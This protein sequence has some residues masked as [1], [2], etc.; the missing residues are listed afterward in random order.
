MTI[1]ALFVLTFTSC[2]LT[3]GFAENTSP[4]Y[5]IDEIPENLKKDADAVIRTEEQ[6]FEVE[7]P[8]KATHRYKIAISILKKDHAWSDFT[9]H[10]NQWSKVTNI[11]AR[12][13]DATGK[14]I[15]KLEKDEINDRAAYDGVS[16]YNDS[17]FKH[18][19]NTYGVV[20]YTFELEYEVKHVG[21]RGYPD[22]DIQPQY[23]TAVQHSEYT[24]STPLSM[25]P[26]FK[27]WNTQ[28]KPEETNSS[29]TTTLKWAANGI[30]PVKS[31]PMSP[32]AARVLPWVAISPAEFEVEGKQGRMTDWMTFGRFLYELN[33]D[34]D[35]ISPDLQ[36]K[37]KEMTASAKTNFEKIDTLY[38]Y[39]QKNMRY[40]SVQL[41]IGGWQTF[42]AS[43]VEQN[44]YGDCKA[45]SN[46]MKAMLKV[47][48]IE[49]VL[50]VVR[51]GDEREL[52][53]S[54]DFCSPAFNHMILHIPSENMWLEC[55]ST[56]A[57]TGY[58]S[59][60]TEGRRVLLITREGGKMVKTPTSALDKNTQ[61]SKTDIVLTESGSA[62][63]KNGAILRGALH[64]SWRQ[65]VTNVSKEE[66]QKTF[67]NVL[68]LPTYT[69]KSLDA[70]PDQKKPE[71]AL[72]YELSMEKYAS[73]AG[74]RLFVPMNLHNP[75]DDTPSPTEK[76]NLPIEIGGDGYAENDEVTFTM[77]EGYDVE[78]I[79]TKEFDYKSE[80]GYY[81]ATIERAG[82]N[83]LVYK[84][85]LEIRPVHIAADRF[86]DLR[87]F[88]KKIQQADTTKVIL[89]KKA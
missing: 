70:K 46:F 84:R 53:P 44:K 79:P 72:N 12:F 75:F 37:V 5:P 32:P 33:K 65:L 57:P 22:W 1:K 61:V 11:R 6:T 4:Q 8:A 49:S 35:K 26:L 31:E 40:I 80:F 89:K 36:A 56:D 9:V 83:K 62:T 19:V 86:N 27:N 21:L 48:G 20:P 51:A 58:L 67:V 78:T 28:I 66:F 87:D 82:D 13:Y 60:F 24:L 23:A 50:T 85:Q 71:L 14:L 76:R 52:S 17:R 3:I 88:Y 69:I 77:P 10:Y 43:Y 25:R 42:E 63:L 73:K 64:D 29:K 45:L 18:I 68:K 41:G 30:E 81:K 7:S 16:I 47:V 34:R 59:D 55:T 39:M 15:R 38:H 2:W 54:E 74:T